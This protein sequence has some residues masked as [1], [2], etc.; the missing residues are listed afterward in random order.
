MTV[1]PFHVQGI[2]FRVSGGFVFVFI[3]RTMDGGI[4]LGRRG[5]FPSLFECGA[6][7]FGWL[8]GRYM[9]RVTGAN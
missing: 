4:L 1:T 2:D 5:L 3:G 8:V 9:G 7:L 6:S